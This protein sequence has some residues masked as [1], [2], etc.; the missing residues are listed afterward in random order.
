MSK[1]KSD[2]LWLRGTAGKNSI[3]NSLW[4]S[5]SEW[6][7]FCFL[8]VVFSIH[9][10]SVCSQERTTFPIIHP[11]ISS[12]FFVPLEIR[13]TVNCTRKCIELVDERNMQEEMRSVKRLSQFEGISQLFTF[14]L[15]AC[16]L[17]FKI[18][19]LEASKA[20]IL[21]CQEIHRRIIILWKWMGRRCGSY[22]LS[23]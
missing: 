22:V 16:N 8:Y 11:L 23:T 17:T 2:L 19:F 6:T 12:P 1:G 4:S 3:F 5:I 18:I 14:L 9:S 15:C 7:M 10:S 20:D 13:M 21:A